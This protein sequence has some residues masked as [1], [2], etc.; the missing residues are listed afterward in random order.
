MLNLRVARPDRD[1]EHS[2]LE[3][4]LAKADAVFPQ[5]VLV[6]LRQA[7]TARGLPFFEF[8][9]QIR[10]FNLGEPVPDDIRNE[11]RR[12]VNLINQVKSPVDKREISPVVVNQISEARTL[13]NT[14]LPR[15]Q[16]RPDSVTWM[17]INDIFVPLIVSV[18]RDKGVYL[19]P[20]QQGT[21]RWAIF[22]RMTEKQ[23]K[24]EKLR[25]EDPESFAL[26]VQRGETLAMIDEGIDKKIQS[27]GLLSRRTQLFGRPVRLGVNP[28]TGE[29]RI[30]DRDGEVLTHEE[31][32]A[33]R[34]QQDD[35]REKGFRAPPTMEAPLSDIRLFSDADLNSLEGDVEWDAITD[36]KAKQ[37]RL[38]RIFA[39]KRKSL[40]VADSDGNIR[41]EK[42]KVIVSGRFKGVYL[43]DMINSQGRM[44]EGTAFGY[45]QVSGRDFKMPVRRDVGAREPYVT[46]AS[47]NTTYQDENGV[48][49]T[50]SE[51]KLFLK[52][53]GSKEF[54]EIRN[55]V[56][57]L[58]CN[59]GAKTG[60]IPSVSYHPVKGS[61]AAC[62][63]FDPKDYGAVRDACAG[64][65]LSKAAL[66]T[67][68]TY[69]GDLARAEQATA[70]DNLGFYSAEALGG[71]KVVRKDPNT[72]ETRKFELLTKQKQAL[73]WMDAKGN[74]GV[75]ALDTGVGKTLT[76]IA[77]M[78]KL[79]RDGLADVGAQYKTP[80]GK[81]I[82]TNGRFLF[83]TPNDLKGNLPKEIRSYISDSG[84][85]LEMVDIV[86]YHEF[87]AA[88]SGKLPG[89]LKDR[90][91]WRSRAA[92]PPSRLAAP[93]A[94]KV[95]DIQLYAAIFFDEAQ[96]LTLTK[97]GSVTGLAVPA[98]AFKAAS[99][100]HPRKIFL[101][102]SPMEKEPEQ[103][104]LL[105]ALSNNELLAGT[106]PEA[107]RNRV[108][109][110][111]FMQRF[112]E[113]VGG[114]IVSVK[115]DP[116]L[117]SEMQ[118]WVKQAIF[119]ADKQN[120]EEFALPEAREE[121]TTVTMSPEVEAAYRATTK[122][123]A[124]M[125]R[126]MALKMKDRDS[127]SGDS[128]NVEFDKEF[129]GNAMKPVM[130]LLN[131]LANNPNAAMR[132]LAHMK[133]EGTMPDRV[134]AEGVPAPLPPILVSV[135]K[136]ITMT[137]EELNLAAK[138]GNPKLDRASDLILTKLEKTN[139][140]SRALVF[141]DDKDLC[142]TA[143][144]HMALNVP[145][146]HA[147]AVNNE[148]GILG[149][150]GPLPYIE[151]PMVMDEVVRM[152]RGDEAAAA[153][154][155]GAAGGV[156]R[157]ALP[158]N[159]RAYRIH[160]GLP[161]HRL[162]NTHYK[163]D[164][165]QQFVLK[166]IV[167][168]NPRIRSCI[169]LGSTYQ[170]GHNL[171]SFDQVIHLDRNT[172]NSESMKQRTARAWRQG[173][174]KPVDVTTI[175]MVYSENSGHSDQDHT[176]DEIRRWFQE[177]ESDLF[178]A[179]IKEAQGVELGKEW[180]EMQRRSASFMRVDREV[181]ELMASPFVTRSR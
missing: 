91:F 71:F 124:R 84:E 60:C 146:W 116:A 63:Y 164:Q 149:S 132:D 174:D 47:L 110:R 105:Q 46:V 11:F 19:K 32:F 51:N 108:K 97:T 120:V 55:A 180:F 7:F 22:R 103:A 153:A 74:S 69:F 106:S 6:K 28:V 160:P 167:N 57:T 75:C 119:F 40:M 78:Q 38:T 129:F 162:Y 35:F 65:S 24:V 53:P 43:D 48:S 128:R 161:A 175:D 144:A 18:A 25:D 122:G 123:F 155:F 117:K 92:L 52:I 152:F 44:I 27:A 133:R 181:L 79:R 9:T 15:I 113:R 109:M 94:G 3:R 125:M 100:Y 17:K 33:K 26:M 107:E 127:A 159:Q 143:T 96:K 115:K 30:Y 98:Q 145:G 66:D 168:V 88:L 169:L 86:S 10:R 76:S 34:R 148:I 54:T 1:L 99:I 12:V 82:R 151:I 166:E 8:Y 157:H 89:S 77:M 49:E 31:F 20:V 173:Q 42:V 73:A 140:S 61:R 5:P 163:A 171:Q 87:R 45:E 13:L 72:D 134:T 36:D 150:S 158:F 67:L 83:V 14:L 95:W 137:W 23:E 112:T 147:V 50:V 41:V 135:L 68:K 156:S 93:V 139:G 29:E 56:K 64:M 138:D 165:W 114:R 131:R 179:I 177:M 126:A 21:E 102:A 4:E 178:D 70:R 81:T 59:T 16:S 130:Q 62:F 136:N 101:T 172:W 90:A 141:T 121:T 170:F 39:T 111:R 118:Q 37:G 80:T 154:A 58:A 142:Q 104:Y 176:L 2:A 85:L